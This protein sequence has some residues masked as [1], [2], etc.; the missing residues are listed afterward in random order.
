MP[1]AVDDRL[2]TFKGVLSTL[3]RAQAREWKD[4]SGNLADVYNVVCGSF[5][6]MSEE[7]LEASVPAAG[8]PTGDSSVGNRFLYLPPLL[9]NTE[10]VPVMSFHYNLSDPKKPDFK[11]AVHLLTLHDGQI[12]SLGYRFETPHGSGTVQVG[13]H[14]FHH[15]Q[16][17]NKFNGPGGQMKALPNCPAWLPTTQ[18]SFPLPAHDYIELLVC[19]LISL[20][21]GHWLSPLNGSGIH[22]L[23]RYAQMPNVMP[24]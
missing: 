2:Q 8:R 15:A 9:K 20:Y 1:G 21:G 6:V 13:A 17:C 12:Y 5:P 14:D 7:D 19:L 18:P 24:S 16:L 3:W 4:V 11:F 10:F 22:N 23:S